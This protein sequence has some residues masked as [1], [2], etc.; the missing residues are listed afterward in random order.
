MSD[1][2]DAVGDRTSDEFKTREVANA[3][4]VSSGS[5]FTLTF[6][7]VWFCRVKLMR[8]SLNR[9]HFTDS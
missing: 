8:I 6:T 7:F 3:S 1:Q 4:F 9:L 2:S 5:T